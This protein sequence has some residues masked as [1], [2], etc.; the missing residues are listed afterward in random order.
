MKMIKTEI[1]LRLLLKD[2]E[3]P[4]QYFMCNGRKLA[5]YESIKTTLNIIRSA[6]TAAPQTPPRK[7]PPVQEEL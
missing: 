7:L 5:V 1:N 4:P 2:L 6:Y 3:K